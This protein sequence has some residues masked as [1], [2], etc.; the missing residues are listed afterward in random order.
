M[1]FDETNMQRRGTGRGS[2][3]ALGS[4]EKIVY[5]GDWTNR[6]TDK[7]WLLGQI[8]SDVDFLTCVSVDIAPL[9]VDKISG[10]PKHA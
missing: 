1:P 4:K 6:Y 8:H 9:G 2:F 5:K 3:S 10:G 7:N